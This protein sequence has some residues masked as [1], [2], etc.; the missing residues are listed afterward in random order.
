VPGKEE[1]LPRGDFT[2]L[3]INQEFNAQ[4]NAATKTFI[5]QTTP[6]STDS[7]LLITTRDVTGSGHQLFINN[8]E[9]PGFDLRPHEGW[10]TSMDHIPPGF[11]K[12]GENT[13]TIE[14]I[15]SDN[16]AVGFIVVHWREFDPT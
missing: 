12:N 1:T 5:V 15:G 6:I 11:L 3:S 14:R 4:N 9:L 10:A 2:W 16:F 13:I 8:K 7:Y